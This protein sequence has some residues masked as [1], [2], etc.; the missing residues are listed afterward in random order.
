MKHLMLSG[1]TLTVFINATMKNEA[2]TEQLIAVD[3]VE[4]QQAIVGGF[5]SV[6]TSCKSCHQ[7]CKLD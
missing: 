6:A 4:D 2:A 5:K 3:E 7:S 1:Q